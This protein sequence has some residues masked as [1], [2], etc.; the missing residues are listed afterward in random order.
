MK[1]NFPDPRTARS[2][3][4]VAVAIGPECATT[5]RPRQQ[6]R[7]L[8]KEAKRSIEGADLA[9][10]T[11]GIALGID[12]VDLIRDAHFAPEVATAIGRVGSDLPDGALHVAGAAEVMGWTNVI[13]GTVFEQSVTEAANSGKIA[14]PNGADHVVLAGRVQEGWDLDLMRGKDV[15]GHAQVKFSADDHTILLH[16]QNH[17]DIPIVITNHEAATAAD[18][19]GVPVIDSHIDYA[20]L[21]DTVHTEVIDHIGFAHFVHEW[22]PEAALVVI[23][24]MALNKL[25][26]GTPRDEVIRWAKEQAAIS[27]IANGAATVVSILTGH[28]VVRLPTAL[29][30]RF[31]IAGADISGAAHRRAHATREA[32]LAHVNLPPAGAA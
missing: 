31:W 7:N 20:P 12:Q 21:H 16:L 15:V 8:L 3:E 14:L 27:G 26:T 22:V 24:G 9:G 17:P 13:A 28:E 6:L 4:T 18:H 19:A 10:S 25:R 1:R 30:T 23:I 2:I 5:A 32:L 29:M 11:V